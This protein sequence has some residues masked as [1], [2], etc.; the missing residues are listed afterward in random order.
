MNPRP[1]SSIERSTPSGSAS[2]SIPSA[3]S[4]SPIGT[5][6]FGPMPFSPCITTG[7][8]TAATTIAD[9]GLITMLFFRPSYGLPMSRRPVDLRR[10]RLRICPQRFREAN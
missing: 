4:T 1:V 2:M 5:P 8:P 6:N 3:S 7:T 9:A 10:D